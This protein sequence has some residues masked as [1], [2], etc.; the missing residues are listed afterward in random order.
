[1]SH[2]FHGFSSCAS[3]LCNSGLRIVI[4]DLIMQNL[5]SS[6]VP[7]KVLKFQPRESSKKKLGKRSFP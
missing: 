2:G 7:I 1:Q 6:S 3:H 5:S 4:R